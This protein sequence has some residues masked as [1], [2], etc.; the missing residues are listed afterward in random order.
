VDIIYPDPPLFHPL[1]GD[2]LHILNIASIS[3]SLQIS[4]TFSTISSRLD[5]FGWP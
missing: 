4:A 2:G 5:S 1:L 3:K